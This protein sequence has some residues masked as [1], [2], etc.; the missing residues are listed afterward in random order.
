M[1]VHFLGTAAAEGFPNPFC[2][3]VACERA[4]KE[5]GKNIRSRTSVLFDDVLKVDFPPDFFYHA[6]KHNLEYASIKDLLITHTH[7]DHFHPGDLF[8]RIESFAHGIEHPLEIYGNDVAM[9]ELRKTL[10]ANQVNRR[11]KYNLV[12]PFKEVVIETAKITPL[13]ADHDRLQTCLLYLIERNGKKVL[14]GNDTGWFPDETWEFLKGKEVDLAILDCTGGYNNNKRS[15]NHMCIETIIEMQKVFK[16][17]NIIVKDGEIVATHFTHNS[18]LLHNEF[19]NAF[20]PYGI[21][22]AYDGMVLN[23]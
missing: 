9:Y 20:E 17:E 21:I 13:V 4:R 6:I 2:L 14:Y 8:N 16:E 3:C 22:V 10:P 5:G 18:G 1:K 15:R 23:L 7:Y 12:H 19:V 11:F